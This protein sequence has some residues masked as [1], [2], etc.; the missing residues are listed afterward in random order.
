MSK[1]STYISASTRDH[2]LRLINFLYAR[3]TNLKHV[4]YSQAMQLYHGCFAVSCRNCAG[5]YAGSP[6]A[7]L[8]LEAC[9]L[10][11]LSEHS[12]V[13]ARK[14]IVGFKVATSELTHSGFFNVF[15]KQL[16]LQARIVLR[17]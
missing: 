10:G 5:L 12:A 16:L 4:N 17:S 13:R 6:G 11:E 8:T 15:F 2:A 7:K 3:V 9:T 1:P 14:P